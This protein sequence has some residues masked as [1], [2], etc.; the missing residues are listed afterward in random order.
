MKAPGILCRCGG[1]VRDKVCDRCGPKRENRKRTKNRLYDKRVWRD[2]V[3]TNVLEAHPLCE[4]CLEQDKTAL[5]TEVHHV[6]KVEDDESMALDED[7]LRALCGECHAKRTRR[8][9]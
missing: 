9:E 4:D 2:V 6:V 8:G 7:N 3:R 1:I 5:A